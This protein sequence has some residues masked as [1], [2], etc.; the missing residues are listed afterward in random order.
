MWGKSRPGMIHRIV[1]CVS[2][3]LVFVLLVGLTFPDR[4][5]DLERTQYPVV[6]L[7][8]S[9]MGLCRD[10]TSVTELLSKRLGKP[11]FNGAFG[12]TCMAVQ[13]QAASVNYT[14]ELLNMVNLSKAIAADDFGV[15]K[16][17]RSKRTITEYFGDTIA[18]LERIDFEKVEVL[19]L[20]FGLNDYHAGISIDNEKNPLDESTYGGALRSVLTTLRLAYPRMRIILATPTYSWYLSNNLTCEEYVTGQARLEE[21]VEKE[22]S[23]AEEFGV[24]L[25]DLYHGLYAHEVWEDWQNYTIDGLHPNETSR[26]T[27]AGILA[28]S[29]DGNR[30]YSQKGSE[31]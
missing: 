9:L 29:I 23:V 28:E 30:Q 14:S 13:P 16:T 17:I 24:E 15:Q 10:E 12:G 5:K 19:I 8:D 31:R 25:I 1:Y 7:G 22:V 26:E 4:T 11:V 27:I 2:T 18:E 6:V 21:Y 20:N 3:V